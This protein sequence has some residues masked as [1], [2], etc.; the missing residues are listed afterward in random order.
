MVTFRSCLH[1][2]LRTKC[3]RPTMDSE[4]NKAT[5]QTPKGLPDH[6][7]FTPSIMDPNSYA[8]TSLANQPSTYYTATPTGMGISCHSQVPDLSTPGMTLNL[9]SPLSIPPATS[10]TDAAAMQSA[11]DMNSFHSFPPHPANGVDSFHHPPPYT[12]S[13]FV[14]R[15]ARYDPL[16]VENSPINGVNTTNHI[17]LIP[18]GIGLSTP[19]DNHPTPG[20]EK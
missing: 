11:I 6:W 12:P 13:G 15:D 16:H 1:V 18:H 14:N 4:E 7:R 10:A 3:N 5:E 19:V 17:G 20:G 9:L 8:F 2:L